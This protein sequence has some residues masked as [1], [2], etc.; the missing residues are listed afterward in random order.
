ME[1]DGAYDIILMSLFGRPDMLEFLS[2]CRRGI[3]RIVSAGSKSGLYPERYRRE[4]KDL[5]PKVQDDL[6]ALGIDFRLTLCTYEFGQ[7]LRTWRDAEMF[8]LNNAPDAAAEEISA[9][10]NENITRTS[11]SD[12]PYYLPYQKELGIFVIEK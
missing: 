11:R 3:V 10:L 5:V 12:F 6:K 8:V 4:E 9:F 1:M 2:H 7:P